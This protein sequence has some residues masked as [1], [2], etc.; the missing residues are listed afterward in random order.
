VVAAKRGGNRLFLFSGDEKGGLALSRSIDLQGGVTAMEVGEINRRDGLDDVVV[1]INGEA[2]A[3]V[4]VFEGPEGA[5]RGQ[6]EAFALKAEAVGIALGQLD[7][8]YEYDL[9]VASGDELLIVA[10]R[11]RK[12][13]LDTKRRATVKPAALARFSLPF[14][15]LGMAVGDF[16]DDKHHQAELALLAT[17]GRVH[18]AARSAFSSMGAS[19]PLRV[20]AEK[21]RDRWRVSV[22]SGHE[23]LSEASRGKAKLVAVRAASQPLDNVVVVD[24][25]RQQ[26]KLLTGGVNAAGGMQAKA[27]IGV[28][29]LDVEDGPVALLPMR[30]N[31]D[32]LSDLVIFRNGRS[33]IATITTRAQ[34]TLLVTN[35]NDSGPGSL[36]QAILDTNTL[37]GAD[38][39]TFSIGS[40]AQTISPLEPL[41]QLTDAVT[42]D[43]TSQPGFAGTPII[44]LAGNQVNGSGA[45]LSI[46]AGNCVIRGLVINR[47]AGDGIHLTNAVGNTIEGNFIGTNRAGNNDQGN[48]GNGIHL[49]PNC[50]GNRIGS[51]TPASRNL[52]SGNDVFGISIADSPPNPN[53][54][55][56]NYIGTDI[57]GTTAIRNERVGAGIFRSANTT[58]GGLTAGSR[59]VVSGN[60]STGLL[61]SDRVRG[62][63][64]QETTSA[65]ML[66][67]QR[68]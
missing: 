16:A 11:D 68:L 18:L 22:W 49:F 15:A 48:Q 10:G 38:T 32:A 17:D 23:R 26:I 7:D 39:I 64:I 2:G 45:G 25:G 35:A 28:M 24:E 56:G 13:S 27:T 59:N 14:T 8:E 43:G 53:S 57:T 1:G 21:A 62:T 51:S 41:P 37:P 58:V 61:V 12:L 52:L 47:F 54:L 65:L 44:E 63:V 46:S 3:P 60:G 4:L 5:L 31:E 9:A 34:N 55:Q 67:V 20:L 29:T 50:S 19:A 66:Q 36:R 40:G 30:M 33:N 42:I 6:P